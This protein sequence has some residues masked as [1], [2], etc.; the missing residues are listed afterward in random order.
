MAG[1]P[2]DG[3]VRAKLMCSALTETGSRAARAIVTLAVLSCLGLGSAAETATAEH[4][5]NL[6]LGWDDFSRFRLELNRP[7]EAILTSPE[8]PTAIAWNELVASWNLDCPV[9]A[10]FEAEV[11]GLYPDKA[12]RFYS[13]GLWSRAA[14]RHPR[15]SRRNQQDADGEVR[16]DTLLLFRPCDRL[17]LRLT[18]GAQENAEPLRLRFVGLC[19]TDPAASCRPL[20]SD[21]LAWGRSVV[22]P[23]RSQMQYEEGGA[24]CSPTSLSM[25]LGFW[26]RRLQRPEL[27]RDVPEVAAAVMDPQWPGTGNWAF[28]MA[29]AGAWPG[30]RAY[31][32]RLSDLA[33]LEAWLAQGLPVAAS[34]CYSALRGGPLRNEG[35]LVVC[36]GFTATGDVIVNDPGTRGPV[37]RTFPRAHFETAWANSRN[38]VYLVYP[39]D[40]RPPADPYG[41]WH[42]PGAGRPAVGEAAR[43]LPDG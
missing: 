23:E 42:L 1:C 40:W 27:D 16:T 41:H 32:T 28:N 9:G 25:L 33:E 37:R 2:L 4:R 21:R 8:I 18:L 38:T 26:S 11:C 39:E 19:L 34:V 7:G 12:T 43:L 17:Q 13:L 15:Q 35:H 10:Y 36:V 20:T 31:V 6:F 14:P 3:C 22:V 5:G 30:L 24:W 29:Y